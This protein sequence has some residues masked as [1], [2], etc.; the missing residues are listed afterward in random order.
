MELKNM[1]YKDSTSTAVL[2]E[3]KQPQIRFPS[4]SLEK[5]IPED[6]MGKDIG[7]MCR[8]E[9]VV[10]IVGKSINQYSE[11]KNERVELEIH[12][13]GYIGKAGKLSKEEYLSKSDEERE[14]Y[15][16]DSME[17]E[18]EKKEEEGQNER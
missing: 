11:N 1:G 18:P 12:K 5:N 14:K 7:E 2:S 10:K 8:L 15:D 3:T 13:L 4:F 17:E 6:L 16:R 9:L